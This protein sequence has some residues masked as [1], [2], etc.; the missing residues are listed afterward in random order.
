MLSFER[1]RENFHFGLSALLGLALLPALAWMKLPLRFD[2]QTYFS[3]YWVSLAA[4]SIFFAVLLYL[5]GFPRAQTI[6]PVWQR[7]RGQKLRFLFLTS[8]VVEFVWL[9]DPATAFLLLV[10][11]LALVEFLERARERQVRLSSAAW[12]LLVPA[13]YLF[14][15]LIIV[16][17]YNDVVASCR[18]YGTYDAAY[19]RM[20]SWF[21]MGT[22]VSE[23]AHKAIRHLP[24][25][26]FRVLEFFYLVMF[27]QIGAG[28]IF[29][30]LFFGK[31]RALQFVGTILTAYY[32]ALL[33][34]YLW[35]CEGPYYSC[36]THFAEFPSTLRSY[37]AQEYTLANVNAVWEHRPKDR[38]GV[39]Y[40]I[41]FPCMYIV[42]PLIVLWFLRRWR[43]ILAFLVL[44][45]LVILVSILLL[46]WHYLVDVLG[47]VL[48]TLVAIVAVNGSQQEPP[49]SA[50]PFL[51]GESRELVPRTG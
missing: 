1:I 39:D 36:A 33:L 45:D 47:G 9:F 22:T 6:G 24:L 11:A 15:G 16:F 50:G 4:Q 44:L 2:W 27:P 14:V 51:A 49:S 20:D 12:T 23:I 28:I 48:V 40:Y 34:F 5:I 25:Q 38:I 32:L 42:Q 18:F 7:Y 17:S 21:L 13:A 31:R 43:R 29:T 19:N 26:F 46:E 10:D 35:P 8:L 37:A 41:A 3:T 30:G